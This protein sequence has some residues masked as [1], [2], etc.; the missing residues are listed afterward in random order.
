MKGGMRECVTIDRYYIIPAT[1]ADLGVLA[2][3][4]LLLV[5]MSTRYQSELKHVDVIIDWRNIFMR[6]TDYVSRGVN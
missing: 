4:K 1:E 3:P 5:L 6:R 2:L